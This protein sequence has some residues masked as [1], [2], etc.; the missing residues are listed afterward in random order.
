MNVYLRDLAEVF[1]E[2]NG[3]LSEYVVEAFLLY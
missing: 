3:S 1:Y 2:G